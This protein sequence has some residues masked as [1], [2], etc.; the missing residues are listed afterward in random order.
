MKKRLLYSLQALSIP[1]TG[2]QRTI[3]LII[4]ELI[5]SITHIL[6]FLRMSK[7]VIL[8]PMIKQ[9]MGTGITLDM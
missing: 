2:L 5:T 1:P 3:L 4:G 6:Y 9:Q 8:L 7:K